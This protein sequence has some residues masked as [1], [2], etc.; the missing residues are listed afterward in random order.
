M[1]PETGGFARCVK[2]PSQFFTGFCSTCLVER[3]SN[4]DS[5]ESTRSPTCGLRNEIFEISESVSDSQG[6]NGGVRVRKTLLS[7][8]ELE[9]L[10]EL[11]M[12]EHVS[13][14]YKAD[15]SEIDQLG[16][17]FELER[18]GLDD[19]AGVSGNTS[20]DR[21]KSEAL[22]GESL[23]D[24]RISFWL[25]SKLL[26]AGLKWGSRC[27]SRK[28][29]MQESYLNIGTGNTSVD[30]NPKIQTST[31]LMD[32]RDPSKFCWEKPRHSWD[33][34]VMSKA[35]ACSFS[36]LH[37]QRDGSDKIKGTLSDEY[38]SSDLQRSFG[39]NDSSKAN[40]GILADHNCFPTNGSFGD[41]PL[42]LH[43]EQPCQDINASDVCRK[44][45]NRWCR[46]WD[47][48]LTSPFRDFANRNGHVL[49]R[50][51]SESWRDNHKDNNAR[52]F[53]P[54]V[55]VHV[56]GTPLSKL[57]QNRSFSGDFVAANV[58]KHAQKHDLQKMRDF[59]L[60]RSHSVRRSTAK[61]RRRTSHPLARGF[62]GA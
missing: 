52:H 53:H 48:S 2:H 41:I 36:C 28:G 42:G 29:P 27:S 56:T 17:N 25:P 45:S 19:R 12:V 31:N 1:N 3:L 40:D 46:V 24:N 32:C 30:D 23:K 37:E 11:E 14:S 7:L 62:F 4:V 16:V 21:E 50:S 22:E 44:K 6:K 35:L 10:K 43:G 60:S 61:W 8:F 54:S 20:L 58:N 49:E 55:E 59:K 38:A 5:V 39:A 57:R 18:K 51:L 13:A 34:S 26:M 15:S 33:G 47:W 9:D